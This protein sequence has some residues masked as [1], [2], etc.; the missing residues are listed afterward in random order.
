MQASTRSNA[1]PSEICSCN[2]SPSTCIICDT[3]TSTR[4]STLAFA[5]NI[6]FVFTRALAFT[7]SG[8]HGY[9]SFTFTHGFTF[10]Y[11]FTLAL[12][13][14]FTFVFTPGSHLHCAYVHVCNFLI[15]QTIIPLNLRSHFGS[16]IDNR[17]IESLAIPGI[18]HPSKSPWPSWLHHRRRDSM[19]P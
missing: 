5:F 11:T 2:S 19:C 10:A 16:S 3:F 7:F 8:A 1:C 17:I 9:V 6:A 13:F 15:L 18:K 14:T 12:T 4:A